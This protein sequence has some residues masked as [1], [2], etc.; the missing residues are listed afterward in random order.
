MSSFRVRRVSVWHTARILVA[1]AAATYL[2]FEAL[3]GGSEG[4]QSGNG[5]DPR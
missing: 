3:V 2:G 1:G 5:G 4:G